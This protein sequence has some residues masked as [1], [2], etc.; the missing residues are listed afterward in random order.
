MRAKQLGAALAALTEAYE[1]LDEKTA[2]RLE[3][4]I[5]RPLQRPTARTRRTHVG[6]R[7]AATSSPSAQ[8]EPAI[9][10]APSHGV[11]G[12]LDGAVAAIG[13]ADRTLADPAGLDASRRGRGSRAA[14]RSRAGPRADR[15]RSA[16][17]RDELVRTLGR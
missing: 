14:R 3:E 7:R 1:Q 9:R 2:E 6:V 17:A 12:F 8:F 11:K 13:E 10:G 4:Q 16:P 5:F 15:R